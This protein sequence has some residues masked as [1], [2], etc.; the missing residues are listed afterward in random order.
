MSSSRRILIIGG[1][2]SGL[3][4]AYHVSKRGVEATIIEARPYF[5]GLL[6]TEQIHGCT[7]ETGADSWLAS[8][9]AAAELARD[10]GLGSELIGS[11][12]ALRRTLIF[13]HGELLPFPEGMQLVAPTRFGPIWRSRLLSPRTKARI[14]LDWFRRPGGPLPERSV[15]AF[16]ADHFGSEAVDYLA[17]PLLSGI[18]GGS[19][20]ELS[21]ASVI[22]KLVERERLHGSLVRGLKPAENP[23]SLF[24]S[25]S[26]GLGLLTGALRPES[27]IHGRAEQIARCE[28]GYRVRVNGAWI[29]ARK[30]ILACE[31]HQA[32]RLLQ[33]AARNS[34]RNS[35][36]SATAPVTSP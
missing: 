18:Y 32:A 1:G 31:S 15:A 20:D 3:T 12:D 14:A 22:P 10:L 17:E 26:G 5:G 16:V 27:A 23:P 34:P 8:K 6:H 2:I 30:V 36:Q 7:V 19:P 11:N 9:P 28:T 24:Q 33:T 13:K 35:A 4:A 21:A 29:E 25:L